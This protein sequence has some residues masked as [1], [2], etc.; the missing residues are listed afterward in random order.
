MADLHQPM[1]ANLIKRIGLLF[2]QTDVSKTSFMVVL[3]E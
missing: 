3:I 1:Q 2:D